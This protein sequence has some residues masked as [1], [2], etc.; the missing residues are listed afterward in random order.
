M[1]SIRSLSV[2]ATPWAKQ[3]LQALSRSMRP[4]STISPP[5]RSLAFRP[6]R[7]EVLLE[8]GRT[9][10]R[11]IMQEE[12]SAGPDA[13]AASVLAEEITRVLALHPIFGQFDRTALV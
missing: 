13:T 5:R 1:R 6:K 9:G 2:A 4:G 12:Q 10:E 8:A 3:T 7:D 11:M